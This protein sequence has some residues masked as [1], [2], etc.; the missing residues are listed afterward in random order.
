MATLDEIRLQQLLQPFENQNTGVMNT[1]SALP[2]INTG[3]VY[4]NLQNQNLVD[5]IIRTK[6]AKK[7]W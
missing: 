5:E 4:Q 1:S 2:F 6:Y 3:Q 7:H